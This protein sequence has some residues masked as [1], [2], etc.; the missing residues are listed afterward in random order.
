MPKGMDPFDAQHGGEVMLQTLKIGFRHGM[1]P[2]DGGAGKGTVFPNAV[3]IRYK[4]LSA[5][6]AGERV[7]CLAAG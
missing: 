4:R 6:P 5:V 3:S 7:V 2:L 1:D